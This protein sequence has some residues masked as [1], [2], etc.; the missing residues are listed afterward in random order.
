MGDCCDVCKVG[1]LNCYLLVWTMKDSV[2]MKRK[3]VYLSDCILFDELQDERS[4]KLSVN[5]F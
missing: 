1:S 2:T 5:E 3:V 4:N